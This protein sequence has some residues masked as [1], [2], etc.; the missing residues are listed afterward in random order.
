MWLPLQMRKR[1]WARLGLATFVL[2]AIGAQADIQHNIQL[3]ATQRITWNPVDNLSQYDT[4]LSGQLRLNSRGTS[5]VKSYLQI[6]ANDDDP[7]LHIDK[8]Y[9]KMRLGSNRITLGK[10]TLGWGQGTTFNAGDV[11]VLANQPGPLMATGNDNRWLGSWQ[12]PLGRFSFYEIAFVAPATPDPLPIDDLDQ[13]TLAA[14]HLFQMA[15]WQGNQ[16]ETGVAWQGATQRLMP[17]VSV[18]GGSGLNWH[19]S[20]RVELDQTQAVVRQLVSAGLYGLWSQPQSKSW[21]YRIETVWDTQGATSETPNGA[22][23][24]HMLQGALSVGIN[25]RTNAYAQVTLSPIDQSF[26]TVVGAGI[27]FRQGF[28]LN[29]VITA[30]QGDSDDLFSHR[31][32]GAVDVSAQIKTVF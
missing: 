11:A 22:W 27:N 5:K 25:N 13:Y 14:R 21:N 7:Y 31:R 15:A 10:T 24:R 3:D 17:Y 4:Q 30:G 26:L 8:L 1:P 32:L 19:L 18:Q 23:Y 28:T 29:T 9:A 12:H 2:L 20:A 16:I 6:T